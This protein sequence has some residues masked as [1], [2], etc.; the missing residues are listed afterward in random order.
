MAATGTPEYFSQSAF[1]SCI[2]GGGPFLLARWVF[3]TRFRT[4]QQMAFHPTTRALWQGDPG[5][6]KAEKRNLMEEKPR[7]TEK[8]SANVPTRGDGNR[9]KRGNQRPPG[10]P[11]LGK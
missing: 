6:E 2:L 4:D 7:Q 9:Q 3:S 10:Q 11:L 1:Q 5:P 8:E